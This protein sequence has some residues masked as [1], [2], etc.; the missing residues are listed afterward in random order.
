VKPYW[1]IAGAVLLIPACGSAQ[2]VVNPQALQQLAGIAP[3]PAVPV[4][5]PVPMAPRP[6]A[7]RRKAAAPAPH[8]ILY[9]PPPLMPA[10]APAPTP[11]PVVA[12]PA[13]PVVAKPPVPVTLAFA[14]GS[15]ALPTSATAA[16]K[17]FCGAS[18]RIGIDARAPADPADPSS[19]MRLSLA[20][21]FAVRDA[22]AACGVPGTS[23]LPRALGAAP[24][25]GDDDVLIG[26]AP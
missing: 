13:V 25:G 17:P 20:R 11:T 18:G 10:P 4:V 21:A 3:A 1:L 14:P 26:S 7:H 12:K 2:V 5:A 8:A 16:L 6:H 15:S 22:L 24:G 23:I 19:A 9:S